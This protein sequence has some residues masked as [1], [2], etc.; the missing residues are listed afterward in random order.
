MNFPVACFSG[1]TTTWRSGALELLNITGLHTL[2]LSE[3]GARLRPFTIRTERHLTGY[4]A[5][6]VGTDVLSNHLMIETF[7]LG[8]RLSKDLTR[9]IA[10]WDEAIPERI[11][12]LP[13]GALASTQREP[14]RDLGT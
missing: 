4:R 11:E 12:L 6:L 7:G 5:E 8:H 14:L 2:E 10:E 9:G 3:D 1:Q 13:R